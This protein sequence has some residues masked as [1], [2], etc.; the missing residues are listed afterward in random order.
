MQAVYWYAVLLLQPTLYL[1]SAPGLSHGPGM[2][3]LVGE[4]GASLAE[5]EQTHGNY[6]H[7]SAS[8]APSSRG[9]VGAGA[10][11]CW[12]RPGNVGGARA[13][14]AQTRNFSAGKGCSAGPEQGRGL[15]GRVHRCHLPGR[16]PGCL[17]GHQSAAAGAPGQA[18]GWRQLLAL[19]SLLRVGAPPEGNPRGVPLR[20][21]R[22]RRAGARRRAQ[23]VFSA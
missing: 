17:R 16:V 20:A 11:S 23:L 14:G 22:H 7:P 10:G 19:C 4:A 8:P 15:L 12:S 6:L 3:G 5:N 18:V 1:V 21:A 13:V 9:R 2:G